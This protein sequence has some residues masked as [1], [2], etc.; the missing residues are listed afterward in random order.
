[1]DPYGLSSEQFLCGFHSQVLTVFY[2]RKHP[3]QR[4]RQIDSCRPGA[5]Q[6]F[7]TLF[8]MFPKAGHVLSCKPER[9]CIQSVSCGHPY[10]RS[11]SHLQVVDRVPHI[12]FGLYL[13]VYFLSGQFRLIQESKFFPVKSDRRHIKQRRFLCIH[14][15]SF[16]DIADI[17]NRSGW[18]LRC[19]GQWLLPPPQNQELP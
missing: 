1:M 13:Y 17:L 16:Q 6:V 19:K 9:V 5:F 12:F 3:L 8:H 7:R 2:D 18:V 11:A 14:I 15:Q 4:P 10:G